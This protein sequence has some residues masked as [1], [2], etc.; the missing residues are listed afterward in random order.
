MNNAARLVLTFAL[1][2]GVGSLGYFIGMQPMK[3]DDGSIVATQAENIAEVSEG[4][5]ILDVTLKRIYLDGDVSEEMIQETIWALEDFWAKYESWQLVDMN[6]DRLVFETKVDDISPM[7]KLNGYFGLS[8][9]GVLSIFNGKPNEAKIIHS[10]FQLDMNKLEGHRQ[11]ELKV[12]IPVKSKEGY[13]EVL[14][15]MKQYSIEKK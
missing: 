12:G 2:I 8:K 6:E 11:T 5:L 7:L 13:S 9:D 1:M 10:F 4:P 15:T 3:A 14:E